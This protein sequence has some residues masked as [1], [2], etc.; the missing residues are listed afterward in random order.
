M[1][2]LNYKVSKQNFF[3]ISDCLFFFFFFFEIFQ[4]FIF[5]IIK[6]T[7]LSEKKEPSIIRT[8]QKNLKYICFK[9]KIKRERENFARL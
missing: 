5:V 7:K 1:L 4:I 2:L 9:N 6:R 3:S 8:D